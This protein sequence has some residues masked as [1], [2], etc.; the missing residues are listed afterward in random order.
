MGI[1]SGLSDKGQAPPVFST[2]APQAPEVQQAATAAPRMD[3]PLEIGTFPR[4]TIGPIMTNDQ[5]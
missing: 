1:L 4:L 3:V 2:P 5:H